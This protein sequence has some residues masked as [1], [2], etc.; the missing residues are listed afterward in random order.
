MTHS[1]PPTA[2]LI[3]K[4]FASTFASW[5][6]TV[7]AVI[8]MTKANAVSQSSAGISLACGL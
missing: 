3:A 5:K 7:A 6:N 2:K 4:T 8:T 1:V